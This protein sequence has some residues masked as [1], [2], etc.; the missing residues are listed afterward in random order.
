MKKGMFAAV[1]IGL[2]LTVSGCGF[3]DGV[4]DGMK[5]AQKEDVNP[6][7]EAEIQV[8]DVMNGHSDK[9]LGE[10]AYIEVPM[11]TMKKVTMEQY[12]EFCNQRVKDS[13]YNWF[14][15]DFGDG[16][17]LQFAGSTIDVSTYGTLDEEKCIVED[18]GVVMLTGEDT[19]E[20]SEN[21]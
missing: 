10:Y 15:I 4:K 1:L 5:A 12:A 6:L 21:E 13:G 14:A 19:Y 16:T 18:T 2:M 11:K 7:M 20:Y 3:S 17:G 9:K 8:G